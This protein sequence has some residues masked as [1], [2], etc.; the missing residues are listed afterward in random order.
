MRYFLYF[1]YLSSAGRVV[2]NFITRA[3]D[4]PIFDT[5]ENNRRCVWC[6]GRELLSSGGGRCRGLIR[7]LRTRAE[8]SRISAT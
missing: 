3:R 8:V 1:E 6:L 5:C 7:H 2:E 4:I